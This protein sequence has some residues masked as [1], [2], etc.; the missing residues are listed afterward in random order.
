MPGR[1]ASNWGRIGDF[2]KRAIGERVCADFFQG[3][4][5]HDQQPMHVINI[6]ALGGEEMKL[7]F[8]QEELPDP[9]NSRKTL[10]GA[11]DATDCDG[12]ICG[13]AFLDLNGQVIKPGP[14][15]HLVISGQDPE[16]SVRCYAIKTASNKN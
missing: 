8:R 12:V 2:F 13:Q 9:L 10:L 4:V 7:K 11:E 14:H 5:I 6:S 1:N 16:A 3:T 15:W